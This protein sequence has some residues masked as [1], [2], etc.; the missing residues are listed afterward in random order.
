MAEI[1]PLRHYGGFI[2]AGGTAF[3]T[4]VAVFYVLHS[5]AGVNLLIARI[6]SISVAMVVSFLINRAVTFAMPGVPR[7]AEFLR[8]AAIA[9]MSSALNYALFAGLMLARP[10]TSPTLAIVLATAVS[11]ATSYLGMRL[12]VFRKA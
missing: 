5:E 3:V 8:F 12:A 11:T 7:L 4:D 10:E 6:L 1:S 9:W 2:A